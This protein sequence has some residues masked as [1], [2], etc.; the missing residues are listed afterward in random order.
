M[1]IKELAEEFRSE[2]HCIP[3]DKE[4][5][6]P[7]SIPIMYKEVNDYE[8]PYNLRFI[9]SNKFMMRSLD[10]HVNNLSKLYPCNC[11]NKSNQQIKIKYDDKDIYTRCKSCTKRTK[12]SLDSLKLKC[13]NKYHLTKGNIKKFMLLL[14][15]CVYPYEYMNDW[16]KFN[17][18]ELPSLDKFYWKLNLKTISKEDYKHAQIVWNTFN[19]KNLGGYHD[20]YVQ[21]DTAQLADTFEQFRNVCLK[22]YKL[23]PAYFCTTP[24]LALEACLKMSWVRLELLADI[25]MVLMFEKGIRGGI[26][27]AM[28][29]YASA[30]NK[31][32]PNYKSKLISSYLMY[33]DANNLYGWAMSKKLPIDS[34]KW[35]NALK[36]FTSDFI[37]NY[38]KDSDTGYLLEVDIDYP[39]NL[40]NLHRDLPFLPIKREKLLTALEDKKKYV[41]HMPH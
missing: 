25:D 11:S 9:D 21:S 10:N 23:D 6:K 5:Y 16:D 28:Q 39:K 2:I 41:V 3:E 15:K 37:K 8:I 32:I 30:N 7:F 17:E 18:T 31:Y 20:L 22:E 24:G 33:V 12:Q 36:M 34:F 1:I 19:I 13:P 38:D 40:H 14:K 26:S 35:C 29:G 27:Q 4:K